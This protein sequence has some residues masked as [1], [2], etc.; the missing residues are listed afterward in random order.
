MHY[1][2]SLK[3]QYKDDSII[4]LDVANG[5]IT[6]ALQYHYQKN[7][8]SIQPTNIKTRLSEEELKIKL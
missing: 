3:K 5:F 6:R 8:C 7:S 4:E 1:C 2:E